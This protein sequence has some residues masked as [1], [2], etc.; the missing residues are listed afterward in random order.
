MD[1]WASAVFW[2]VRLILI[3]LSIVLQTGILQIPKEIK[4]VSIFH[5][6]LLT[7]VTKLS[8]GRR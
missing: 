2:V 7:S 1:F 5:N 3:L 4:S 8:K 6:G